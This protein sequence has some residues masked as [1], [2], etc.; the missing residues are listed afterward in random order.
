M[1]TNKLAK[2]K[3]AKDRS[4][5]KREGNEKGLY[6]VHTG[7]G[8]GKTSAA[9]NMWSTDTWPMDAEQQLFSLLRVPMH[10]TQ[11]TD[12]MLERLKE[13]GMPVSIDV[14]GGGFPGRHRTQTRTANAHRPLFHEQSS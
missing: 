1:S 11:V 6:I 7:M 2:L 5:A 14:L 12:S 13:A 10:S 9:M 3:A 4:H 8:K